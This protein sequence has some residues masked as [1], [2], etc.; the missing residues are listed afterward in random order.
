V[1]KSKFISSVTQEKSAIITVI[2]L[3]VHVCCSNVV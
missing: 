1:L 2:V 3:H